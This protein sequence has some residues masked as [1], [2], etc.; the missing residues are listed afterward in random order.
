MKEV[1]VNTMTEV[2][3]FCEN[4]K[5]LRKNLNLSK[6]TMSSMLGICVASLNKIENGSLPPRL[7]CEVLFR[8]QSAFGIPVYV[9]FSKNLSKLLTESKITK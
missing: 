6:K 8:I 4:V 7:S 3:T 2:Y 1:I 9:L 5:R